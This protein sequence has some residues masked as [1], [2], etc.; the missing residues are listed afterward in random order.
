MRDTNCVLSQHGTVKSR[1]IA[2]YGYVREA[3]TIDHNRDILY[4][5]RVLSDFIR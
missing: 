4:I 2:S 5:I 3:K 1:A